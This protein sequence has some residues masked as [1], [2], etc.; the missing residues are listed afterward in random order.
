MILYQG[1]W[2][3]MTTIFFVASFLVPATTAISGRWIKVVRSIHAPVSF[4]TLAGVIYFGNVRS[5]VEFIIIA[6]FA[7]WCSIFWAIMG[8][9]LSDPLKRSL[10]VLDSA[11]SGNLGARV[12]MNFDRQDEL[13]MV[14]QGINAL[15]D[16]VERVYN[17]DNVD[18]SKD[19]SEVSAQQATAAEE[20]STSLEE[21]FECPQKIPI[22]LDLPIVWCNPQVIISKR[23]VLPCENCLNLLMIFPKPAQKHKR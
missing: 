5:P 12:V 16:S 4:L 17:E 20:I 6:C 21:I 19:L 7:T 14:T 22:M 10:E 1:N 18:I 11:K 2:N 15:L 3:T 13:G 9:G 8:A 23:L